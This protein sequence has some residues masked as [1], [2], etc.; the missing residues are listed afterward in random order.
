MTVA[1]NIAQDTSLHDRW[2]N[3]QLKDP[4]FR[5]EFEREQREIAAID[6]IVNTLEGVRAKLGIS[7]AEL[8]RQ[9]GKNPAAVRRLLTAPINPELR[10]VVNLA[11][12]LGYEVRVVPKNGRSRRRKAVAA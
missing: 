6:A 3:E 9:I 10:T 12:A 1:E 4:E 11:D 5:A 8:A 7:K 2:L